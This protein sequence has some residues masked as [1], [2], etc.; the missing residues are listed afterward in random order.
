MPAPKM[1]GVQQQMGGID[2]AGMNQFQNMMI[3]NQIPLYMDPNMNMQN[4]NMQNMNMQNMQQMMFGTGGG[5]PQPQDPSG[6]QQFNQGMIP[7]GI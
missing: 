1:Q 4:M 7:I 2:M 6:Q 3:Q 5:V